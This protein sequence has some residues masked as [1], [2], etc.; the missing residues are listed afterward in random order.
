MTK[1]DVTLLTFLRHCDEAVRL[2]VR[3]HE[4]HVHLHKI[5][6]LQDLFFYRLG[7][8]KRSVGALSV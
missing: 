1:F 7:S 6:R 5:I 3:H 2:S 8:S 4:P